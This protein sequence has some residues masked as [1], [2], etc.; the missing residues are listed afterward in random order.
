MFFFLCRIE[1]YIFSIISDS[2]AKF[3]EAKNSKKDLLL[4]DE[5]RT[6]L[7]GIGL[8]RATEKIEA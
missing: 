2:K 3:S 7:S 1:R 6:E 8:C 5:N 4:L